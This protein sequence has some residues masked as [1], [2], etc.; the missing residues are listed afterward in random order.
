MLVKGF[1]PWMSHVISLKTVMKVFTVTNRTPA[2]DQPPRQQAALAEA[3]HAV[4]LAH[5]RRLLLQVKG[6]ARRGAGHQP[7]GSVEIGVHQLGRFAGLEI[8]HRVIHQRAQFLAPL[9]A[10]LA[11]LL[12]RQQIGHLEILGRRIGIEHERIVGLAEEAGILAVRQIAAGRPHRLGQDDVRRQFAAPAFQKL[13]RAPGVRRIDAA[14]EEPPGL[15]HLVP[16]IVHRRRRVIHAAHQRKL[17]RQLRHVRED[18]RDLDVRVVGLDGLE[19]PANF[20][21][22]IRLRVPGIDLARRAEIEDHDAGRA[23]PCPRPPPPWRA[24]EWKSGS[25]SPM[26]LSVP[27]CRKSRRVTPSQFTMEPLPVNLNMAV[28]Q[29]KMGG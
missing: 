16:G 6:L 25:D 14:G 24:S 22:R 9:Q 1:E 21:R 3:V 18:F 5:A 23:R 4:A 2:L 8:L 12:R 15:H 13:Q 20:A 27:A 17:V 19:R 7:V 10:H 26:A 28:L 29:R 11:D